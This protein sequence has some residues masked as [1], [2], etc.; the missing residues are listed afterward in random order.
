MF[1]EILKLVICLVIIPTEEDLAI[2]TYTSLFSLGKTDSPMPHGSKIP[3]CPHTQDTR[4]MY[5]NA[6]RM[7]HNKLGNYSPNPGAH[8][9]LFI[10]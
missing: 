2:A 3:K 6:M 4:T 7:I 1:K 9:T 5:Q 8:F 10:V